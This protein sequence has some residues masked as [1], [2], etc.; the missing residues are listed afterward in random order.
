MPCTCMPTD[1]TLLVNNHIKTHCLIRL[2][3]KLPSNVIK[4]KHAYIQIIISI[5]IIRQFLLLLLLVYSIPSTSDDYIL[6][7]HRS[8]KYY[9]GRVKLVFPLDRMSNESSDNFMKTA[10]TTSILLS[11]FCEY[12][13]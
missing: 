7:N 3:T 1:I 12:R 10:E 6:L 5:F 4:K 13:F 8:G 9:C 2:C 11:D